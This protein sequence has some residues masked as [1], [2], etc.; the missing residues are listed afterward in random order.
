MVYKEQRPIEPWTNR[1]EKRRGLAILKYLHSDS[2]ANAVFKG[3]PV[4][5][6]EERLIDASVK[7]QLELLTGIVKG[8][9]KEESYSRLMSQDQSFGNP[10]NLYEAMMPTNGD[11]SEYQFSCFHKGKLVR[12]AIYQ[13]NGSKV[14]F[15]SD[16]FYYRHAAGGEGV[17]EVRHDGSDQGRAEIFYKVPVTQDD[18]STMEKRDDLSALMIIKEGFET[19][20]YGRE[21]WEQEDFKIQQR[22]TYA[23]GEEVT[24]RMVYTMVDGKSFL[25]FYATRDPNEEDI[26]V[27]RRHLSKEE[28]DEQWILSPDPYKDLDY[29]YLLDDLV[30]GFEPEEDESLEIFAK[31]FVNAKEKKIQLQFEGEAIDGKAIINDGGEP[32][33]LFID[34]DGQLSLLVSFF[35]ENGEVHSYNFQD[36]IAPE[37]PSLN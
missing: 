24:R 36:G 16:F 29:S 27:V 19:T 26:L 5:E 35:P 14:A 1:A 2:E 34:R 30:D 11:N 22:S 25:S 4:T 15:V 10:I 33:M 23:E 31:I 21:T 32:A 7:R 8:V 37:N 3:F 6:A 20:V 9:D 13:K 12:Q 28:I 18:L 17:I